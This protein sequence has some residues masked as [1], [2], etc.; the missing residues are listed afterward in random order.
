VAVL[1][2]VYRASTRSCRKSRAG[3]SSRL[4]SDRRTRAD[5]AQ[6]SGQTSGSRFAQQQETRLQPRPP[7]AR[8]RKVKISRV[9]PRAC[10]VPHEISRA[11]QRSASVPGESSR[12]PARPAS[13]R[14]AETVPETRTTSRRWAD[15]RGSA[16][17]RREI[18]RDVRPGSGQAAYRPS[19]ALF[20]PGRMLTTVRRDCTWPGET[21]TRPCAR[22]TFTFLE[23]AW[24]GAREDLGFCHPPSR[25]ARPL[26]TG[27]GG[28]QWGS[29]RE[30]ES[31]EHP[32]RLPRCTWEG[33]RAT[34]PFS[35]THPGGRGWSGF[36]RNGHPQRRG[37][38]ALPD[39]RIRE[40]QTRQKQGH[41]REC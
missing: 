36:P 2:R 19:A 16:G 13:S 34:R 33:K 7:A 41:R 40:R 4:E 20:R 28:G 22:V 23:R 31:K 9:P 37:R 39:D 30:A 14:A 26:P 25:P 11:P 29:R 5:E 38:S 3:Y 15:N 27:M 21:A 12:A 8:G 32:G 6:D 17:A 10:S 24:A 35:G 18:P 1:S